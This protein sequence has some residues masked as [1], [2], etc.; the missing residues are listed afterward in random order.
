M[1]VVNKVRLTI[2][3]AKYT[4]TTPESEE[5]VQ[6][7]AEKINR[8]IEVFLEKGPRISFNDALVLCLLDYAD[9][10]QKSERSADHIRDQL[11]GY[12]GDASKARM[13]ADELRGEVS[14]LRRELSLLKKGN[15]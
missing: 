7:L 12:L 4:V 10:R 5:Y 8:D 1:D 9:E 2:G 14:R 15:V 11:T 13:E 3:G 6:S